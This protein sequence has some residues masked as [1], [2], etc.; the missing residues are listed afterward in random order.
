[1]SSHA[2]VHVVDNNTNRRARIARTLYSSEIHAEVYENLAELEHRSPTTGTLLLSDELGGS[3]IELTMASMRERSGY[4]PFAIFSSHPSPHEI[5]KAMYAGALDFLE[6]PCATDRLIESVRRVANLGRIRARVEQRK[7]D[8]RRAIAG[9]SPRELDVLILVVQ[10]YSNKDAANE[11]GISPRT[12]EIHRANMMHRLNADSAADAVRIGLY[13]GLDQD[14]VEAETLS[15][16][17]TL[18]RH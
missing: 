10:G 17:D 15:N 2:Y 18:A 4:V 8:A 1:M 7:L 12:V 5:V 16:P 3:A 11:L 9:L 14:D 6:W 13:A